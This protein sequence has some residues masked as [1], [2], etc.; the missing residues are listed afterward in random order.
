M[1]VSKDE[2]SNLKLIDFGL[3]RSYYKIGDDGEGK[4]TRMETTAG[5]AYFMAPEVL[6]ESYNSACDMW[7]IG[8]ILYIMLWGYPPFDGQTE[9]DIL[10]AVE[11]RKFDFDDKIWDNVSD[12]AK[13]L[14]NKL[15]VPE[16]ERLSPKE[17]LKHP[18]IVS[19]SEVSNG[20][21]HQF[22]PIHMNRLKHFHKLANFKKVV[23]T[24]IAS[25][26]TD[27]EIM[28]EMKA[29]K[30]L[31]KN[32]DGYITVHEL[33]SG[34][35]GRLGEDEIKEILEGVDTDKN[36]AI[37][38]TEFIAATLDQKGLLFN[39]SSILKD[40]FQLFDKDND[41]MIDQSELMTTLAGAESEFVDTKIWKEVL[42]EW[43]RIF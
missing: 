26:T 12:D 6:S 33:K 35:K 39:S 14:I 9:D 19:N 40:A 11:K 5:T 7:S 29:F 23:L 28:E 4:Y 20:V 8:V 25:R 22:K 30:E 38:Y 31:D 32:K 16:D 3:S 13:D 17:A 42:Q 37:N 18:W 15:L 1:F 36:G 27:K 41:G 34:L 10:K 43:A 24:F 21:G 2:D